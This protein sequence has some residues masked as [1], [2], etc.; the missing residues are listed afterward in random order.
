MKLWPW[1]IVAKPNRRAEDDGRLTSYCSHFPA[2]IIS[3]LKEDWNNLFSCRGKRWST[4]STLNIILII[5]PLFC[6][7]F[8]L[9][10]NNSLL[11][12]PHVLCSNVFLLSDMKN[13]FSLP[14]EGKKCLRTVSI[15]WIFKI[16]IKKKTKF[17]NIF[18]QKCL[19]VKYKTK[20]YMDG[21]QENNILIKSN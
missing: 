21:Y 2:K 19:I 3:E 4:L 11:G 9:L 5:K 8:F 14:F 7:L 17:Y 13:W 15:L 16:Y 10:L 6:F 20:C 12:P 18:L 1:L